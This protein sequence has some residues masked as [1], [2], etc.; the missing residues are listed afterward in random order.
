MSHI[1]T[2]FDP[3]VAIY[4]G[5]RTAYP[6]RPPFHPPRRYPEY[7]FDQQE[8]D[9]EN[10]VYEA[11]RQLFFLLGLDREHYGTPSWNPLG[12]IVHPG[13]RVI[14]KPNLVISEHLQGQ[15]GLESAVVH[16]AVVRPV[17]DYVWLALQGRG[18]IT[19]LDSPIKE[20]DF[21][22]VLMRTGIGPTIDWLT[23]RYGL[24]IQVL[25]LRQL[26]VERD[27]A[28]LMVRQSRLPGDPA[29]YR[30]IDLGQRSMFAEVDHLADRFRSTAAVYENAVPEAH[31]QG[32]H[33]YSL[34]V[35]VLEADAVISLAK[36]K[37]HRKAG[38][39]LSLKNVV[40]LT[41]E[42]RWLPHH[43]LGS[44]RDGGDEYPDGTRLDVRLKG[45]AREL[46][47]SRPW[48][49]SAARMIGLPVL[50]CYER[51]VRPVLDRLVEQGPHG[52]IEE[53]DWFGNDTVWRMALD[54]NTVLFYADREG[55]LREEPQRRYLGLVD[56]IVGGM[57]EGPLMPTPRPSGV[58]AAGLN[59][60]ALD[61]VCARLMGFDW[62]KIPLIR[63]AA[64]REWLPLGRFTLA[65]LTVQSNSERWR[66]LLCS[67]DP[68]LAFVAPAGWRGH[69]EVDTA[70]GAPR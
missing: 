70:D 36:M 39:T 34:P 30:V 24:D 18:K 40:G 45:W 57:E 2:L 56:G 33:L 14:L 5:Q 58:L 44:P 25:D 1:R 38:V 32:R 62:T 43:R 27:A 51:L 16:G 63:K 9:P 46:L 3:R 55:V 15:S 10:W 28:G 54:L 7:P 19:L 13:D 61:M 65:D 42:K 64:E 21:H 48:G 35:C 53:G 69:I 66:A 8:W 67:Q 60:V 59:P 12:E 37:T 26:R 4:D 50:R 29:G 31:G 6:Q 47:K 22:A 41:N 49:R 23:R 52:R 68:G 11:V 20:T 17:I